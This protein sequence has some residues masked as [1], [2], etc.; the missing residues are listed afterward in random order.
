MVASFVFAQLL[1]GTLFPQPSR[2][3]VTL[4]NERGF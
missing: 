3:L 2:E 1:F 4:L